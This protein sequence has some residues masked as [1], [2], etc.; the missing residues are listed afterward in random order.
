MNSILFGA[1]R[2]YQATLRF[3]GPLLARFGLT[4]ARFDMLTV[5]E[6]FPCGAPQSELREDL[7][8]SAATISRMLRSLEELGFV[9]REREEGDRRRW[10]VE[11]TEKGRELLRRATRLLTR[12]VRRVIHEALVGVER[13]RDAWACMLEMAQAEWLFQRLRDAFGDIAQ[14]HY[15]WH[16][17]D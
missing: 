7:G 10:I 12:P 16:P 5:I 1:K 11:L 2:A 4:P 13:R 8:V 14:L 17:D 9:E 6:R 15:A 3:S